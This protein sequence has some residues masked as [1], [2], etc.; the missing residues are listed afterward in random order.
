MW[1]IR[2]EKA[3]VITGREENAHGRLKKG[4]EKEG[5]RRH[6][7]DKEGDKEGDKEE[8]KEENDAHGRPKE[9]KKEGGRRH[10]LLVFLGMDSQLSR[11][12]QGTGRRK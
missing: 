5:G 11:M 7:L 10:T 6:T 2:R 9:E 12:R 4:E 3:E 1:R 8:D